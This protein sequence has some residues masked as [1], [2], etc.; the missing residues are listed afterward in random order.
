MRLTFENA[1]LRL[2]SF[3]IGPVGPGKEDMHSH[4][5]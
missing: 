5:Y 4:V 2:W 3:L 1:W